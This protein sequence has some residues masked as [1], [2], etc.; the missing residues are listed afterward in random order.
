MDKK[1]TGIY[2]SIEQ[3]KEIDKLSLTIVKDLLLKK[4]YKNKK[5][6]MTEAKKAVKL[7]NKDE[8]MK[9]ELKL[10]YAKAYR[11][12]DNLSWKECKMMKEMILADKEEERGKDL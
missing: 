2:L 10:A 6:L 3:V 7:S 12:L 9:K 8:E 1:D 5:E 11:R 4:D